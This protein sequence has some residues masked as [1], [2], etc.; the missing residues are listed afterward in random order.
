LRF[1]EKSKTLGNFTKKNRE[2]LMDK[3][4]IS[5]L[6]AVHEMLYFDTIN[7]KY[8]TENECNRNF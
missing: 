1:K 6:D 7:N 2:L 3:G 4:K 8:V 5:E